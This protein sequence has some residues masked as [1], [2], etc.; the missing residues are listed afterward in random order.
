MYKQHFC[1]LQQQNIVT[2]LFINKLYGGKVDS[3]V[4][5]LGITVYSRRIH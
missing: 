2:K 3:D 5:K 1:T 4:L